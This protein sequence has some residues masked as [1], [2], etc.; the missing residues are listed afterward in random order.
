[1]AAAIGVR[2]DYDTA[3]L[4]ELAKRS[5]DANQTRRL[6][7]LA[8]IYDGGSRTEAAKIGGVGLQTVRDWVLAFNAEGPPGLVNGKAPGNAPLLTQ[9]HRQALL[10]IVESGPIPAVHGVV[11]WRLID[12]AQWVFDEFRIS[13]SKQTLSRELRA[14]ELRKL[15]ARPRHHAQ[16]AEGP[17]GVQKNFA[18]SLD[19][20]AERDAAGKP[21]EIWFQDEAR[22][23][24]KNKITRRWARRGTRPSAP[25]DQRTRSTYI[26]GAICPARGTG[27][28]LIL[29]RCNTAAMALHLEEISQTVTPGAH[30]VVLL[31]QAGWHL[32]DKLDIPGNITLLPLPPKSPEL[33]P[34][35][36]IWQFMRDN[37]LS[38]RVFR[39]Y[40]DIL[41]HCCYAWNKL[42]DQPWTIMSIGLRHWAHGF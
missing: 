40:D 34:V 41:E 6:L 16:D 13:I 8:A 12:L 25:H 30:A 33:N 19:E 35:E 42:V 15:S 39:S 5:E 11:R 29:P 32:S 21:I 38:N 20:I 4:R 7:A 37:W 28:G 27:A 10:E 36:N 26:F 1:M 3:R 31:D 23:G 2:G 14:L 18:E 22:I 24:Q 9:A 17:G